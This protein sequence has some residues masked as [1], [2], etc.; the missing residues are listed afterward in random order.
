MSRPERG[1]RD[2]AVRAAGLAAGFVVLY[3]AG[4]VAPWG[5]WVDAVAFS[6]LTGAGAVLRPV[7]GVAREA[8]VLGLGVVVAALAVR[9]VRDRRWPALGACLGLA[10]AAVLALVLRGAVLPRPV[11]EVVLGYPY[12]TFPSTHVAATAAL[13]VALVVLWPGRG[14]VGRV[15]VREVA[16]AAV[17]VACVVNVV[18][19]AHRPFD[20]LGS[21]L[22]VGAAAAAA[23]AV[24]PGVL[25][26]RV[27]GKFTQVGALRSRPAA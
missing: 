11:H 26:P 4:V 12:N 24:A 17:V 15:V 25:S 22:L 10:A 9:A 13:A 16:L 7:A 2:H 6:V 3:L 27:E 23:S 20:V 1:R 19:F 21:L 14:A 18:A 8:L 5:Q